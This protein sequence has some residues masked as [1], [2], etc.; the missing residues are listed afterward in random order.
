MPKKPGCF[1]SKPQLRPPRMSENS[2]PP[3]Q[4]S[5]PWIKL[6]HETYGRTQD[7]VST[8]D[9]KRRERRVQV[10]AV[11]ERGLLVLGVYLGLAV[12]TVST[13][14]GLFLSYN[15]RCYLLPIS[16]LTERSGS[17]H[18]PF[19]AFACPP[20]LAIGMW[21]REV[22]QTGVGIIA[23]IRQPSNTTYILNFCITRSLLS[24]R[25]RSLHHYPY[26][27]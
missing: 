19:L 22:L 2:S 21:S 13:G 18:R 5:Y 12:I 23:D 24:P 7:P 6:D 14:S 25:D 1:S 8:Y 3:S 4:R 20:S 9:Q 26:I 11:V 15:S 17:C 16:R 27:K 10:L